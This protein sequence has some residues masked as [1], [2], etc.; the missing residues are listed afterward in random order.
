MTGIFFVIPLISS[1][2]LLEI[3]GDGPISLMIRDNIKITRTIHRLGLGLLRSSIG[4]RGNAL[5]LSQVLKMIF[6]TSGTLYIS[7][8]WPIVLTLII[9]NLPFKFKIHFNLLSNARRLCW[10]CMLLCCFCHVV[11]PQSLRV[12]QTL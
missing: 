4:S 10:V 5:A 9:E 3:H 1:G 7:S 8:S 6:S 2:I 12:S 11:G